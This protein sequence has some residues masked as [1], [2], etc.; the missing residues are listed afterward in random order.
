MTVEDIARKASL[1]RQTDLIL[2]DFSKAFDKVDH[3]KFIWNLH[4]YGVWSNVFGWIRAFLGNRCQKLVVGGK[5]S[6]SVPVTSGVTQGSVL[7]RFCTS[8]ISMTFLRTS[9]YLPTI[10]RYILP[11]RAQTTI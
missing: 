6:D 9:A 8:Y 2:L 3:S 4:Q 1:G 5:K 10:R 7:G 11:L